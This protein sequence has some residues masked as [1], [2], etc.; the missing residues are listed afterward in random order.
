LKYFCLKSIGWLASAF[1]SSL[2]SFRLHDA[3]QTQQGRII[4]NAATHF[5]SPQLPLA[6]VPRYD[7]VGSTAVAFAM[8]FIST[9]GNEWRCWI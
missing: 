8:H 4:K 7:G 6:F 9:I 3:M 5:G 2:Q 1:E